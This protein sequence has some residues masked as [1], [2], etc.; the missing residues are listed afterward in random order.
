[1]YGRESASRKAPQPQLRGLEKKMNRFLKGLRAAPW[2]W[3]QTGPL[4]VDAERL[5]AVAAER[6]PV[7]AHTPART[8]VYSED[9]AQAECGAPLPE[10]IAEETLAAV[11]AENEIIESA[12]PALPSEEAEPAVKDTKLTL[13]DFPALKAAIESFEKRG[14][15]IMITVDTERS[16]S[17]PVHTEGDLP[18]R[19]PKPRRA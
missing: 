8:E 4:T 3:M 9:A 2:A 18:E 19:G 13:D 12:E 10:G 6:I 1:M 5:A 15:P 11:A 7:S 17:E 16:G 14:D